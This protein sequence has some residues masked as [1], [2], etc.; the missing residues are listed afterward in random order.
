MLLAGAARLSAQ[1]VP[2]PGKESENKLIAVLKSDAP[3]KEKADACRQLAI[4]ATEDAVAPLAALLSDE[5]LSHM[6]RYALEPIPH[7][8][9]DRALRNALDTLKGRPLV[10]VIDSIGVRRDAEAVAKLA[11][12]LTDPDPLVAQA[13][14]RSLGKIGDF[15]ASKAL[16]KALDKSPEANRLAIFEGLFRCA[17]GFAE[18]GPK[19]VAIAIYDQLRSIEAPHQV[20]GGALRGA[21]LARGSDGLMLLR[22]HLKSDDY[23][24]FSAAV[25]TAQELPGRE[26]T[27]VLTAALDQSPT[28]NKILML[29]T[30][31]QRA[32]A[33]AIPAVLKIAEGAEAP[34]RIAALKTLGQMPNASIVDTLFK[35]AIESDSSVAR[36]ARDTLVGLADLKDIE[37]AFLTRIE[38]GPTKARLVAIDVI[39]ECRTAGANTLLFKAAD[40]PDKQIRIAAIGAL[41]QT[42]GPENL[43]ALVTLLVERKDADEIRAAEN[44]T[45]NI[46]AKAPDKQESART[47]LQAMSGAS[48]DAKCALIRLLRVPDGPDALQAVRAAARDNDGKIQ[49]TAV[50]T[51]CEWPSADAAPD[52]LEMARAAANQARKI[53]ALR[54]YINLVRDETLSTEKKMQM[55]AQAA[56][57]V[58]RDQEK[59]L[60]LGV[61]GAIPTADA[62]QMAMT[63]LDNASTKQ[64]ASLAAVAIADKIAERNPAEVVEAMQ[65]VLKATNNRD[66]TRQARSALNK[67]R[68]AAGS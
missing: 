13:T 57:L 28:D 58:Q 64:E 2:P 17:E 66:I 16:Q 18:K 47:L 40:D 25:Q 12:M 68:K 31:G 21:I 42:G 20:R 10:G 7:P 61:L 32:D 55:A 27:A 60:L 22:Q 39:A 34:I 3:Q 54:G 67:A 48:A 5:K 19:S 6:A 46:C 14:A 11:T 9:V 43:S 33:S 23:I 35:A 26:V 37:A 49:E 50:R 53:A 36:T 51:L 59:K 65:K 8:S 1:T 41:G 44:S 38:K 45:K 62:L 63:H 15:N 29:Q 4:I 56:K 52:L 24:L 30:L